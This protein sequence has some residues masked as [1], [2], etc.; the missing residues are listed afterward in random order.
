LAPSES[1]IDSGVDPETC[2]VGLFRCGDECA[3]LSTDTFHC[4]ACGHSCPSSESCV[5]GVCAPLGLASSRSAEARM[6][7]TCA[8]QSDGT[9]KCAGSANS[10]ALG[11]APPPGS[12]A[13]GSNITIPTPVTVEGLSGVTDVATGHGFSCALLTDATV[14]CWGG[15]GLGQLGD[16]TTTSSWRPVTVAGLSNVRSIAAG[17]W[18]T[19]ALVKDGTVRCWGNR[20]GTSPMPETALSDVVEIGCG[21]SYTCARSA[22][23]RVDCWGLNNY[24]QLG[25]GTTTTRLT[26]MPALV[27]HVA[28]LAVGTHHSCVILADHTVKCWGRYSAT[29]TLVPKTIAGFSGATSISAAARTCVRVNDGTVRCW[30]GSYGNG[31]G[32]PLP[33][34]STPQPLEPPV[35]VLTSAGTPLQN[36][37]G[38][39]TGETVACARLADDSVSCWGTNVD[40][41][42]GNGS[43]AEFL[44]A[45]P[46]SL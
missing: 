30:G 6:N 19:C 8:R 10:G 33:V 9:V 3:R 39:V 44:F 1:G 46:S 14:R 45:T 28:K 26:L 17:A 37:K 13:S 32:S 41:A 15:N 5:S 23:G 43:T 36:V 40:G 18:H 25:D 12:D 4:G 38:V 7:H 22:S 27:D 31:D 29:P 24:G 20:S 34:P 16:G 21:N 42:F 35:V 2:A 11:V